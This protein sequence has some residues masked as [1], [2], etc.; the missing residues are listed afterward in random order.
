MLSVYPA[1]FIEELPLS[2]ALDYILNAWEEEQTLKVWDMWLARYP[3]MEL[4]FIKAEGFTEFRE[5]LTEKKQKHTELPPEKIVEELAAVVAAYEGR[6]AGA[7]EAEAWEGFEG[8]K[9]IKGR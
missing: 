9:G 7:K 3:F 4:G 1:G 2:A 8:L 6:E 5:R